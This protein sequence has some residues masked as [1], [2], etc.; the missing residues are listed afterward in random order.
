MFNTHIRLTKFGFGFLVPGTGRWS[1]VLFLPAKTIKIVHKNLSGVSSMADQG[2][3]I[4]Q[5]YC[6][7]NL[8]IFICQISVPDHEHWVRVLPKLPNSCI[9]SV[10]V[11]ILEVTETE[12]TAAWEF[13]FY[14]SFT[15]DFGD[16]LYQRKRK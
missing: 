16:S 8:S 6:V 3:I 13:G 15:H 10:P 1:R 5:N 11:V 4:L 2:R 12:V 9:P 14:L 7:C